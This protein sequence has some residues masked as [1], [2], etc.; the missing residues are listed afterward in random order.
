MHATS[1]SHGAT[2]HDTNVRL[3]IDEYVRTE[4]KKQKI[5]GLSLVIIQNN[6][7]VYGQGYGYSNIE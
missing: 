7:I 4:M 5:P 3:D 1:S 6:H 2:A